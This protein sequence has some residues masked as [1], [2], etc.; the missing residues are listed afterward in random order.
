MTWIGFFIVIF[1][2]GLFVGMMVAPL[3]IW[4]ELTAIRKVLAKLAENIEVSD[5]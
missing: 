2:V 1:A 3:G 4:T 5:S